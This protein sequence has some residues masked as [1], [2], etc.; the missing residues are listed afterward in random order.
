MNPA[1][2]FDYRALYELSGRVALVVGGGSGIGQAGAEG[3]AAFGAHVIVA[4]ILLDDAKGVSEGIRDRGGKSSAVHVDVRETASVERMVG[5]IVKQH[6]RL[7][8]LLA[9]PAV[10]LRKRLLDYSDEEFDRVIELNLKGTFRVARASARA[11]LQNRRGSIILMSS[12]RAVNVEPGQSIYASTKAGIVQ[13]TRGL[14]AELG[15]SGVRVNALAPGIVATPLTRPITSNPAW[16]Q[17]YA[18]HS[19]LGRWAE[20]E[21]MAGPIVFLASDASSYVTGTTLFADAGWTA[22]DGRFEPQL[23]D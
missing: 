13:M 20:P 6:G 15:A 23:R 5:E 2:S 18:R 4:D 19:A 1:K 14:A 10:N 12:M 8:V 7:D 17:A 16:T 11:M 3:I 22:I 21:E 9:T